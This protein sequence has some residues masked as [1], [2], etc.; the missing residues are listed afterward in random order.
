[1]FAEFKY[2]V[3][4]P[5]LTSVFAFIEIAVPALLIYTVS[6]EDEPIVTLKALAVNVPNAKSPLQQLNKLH[7]Q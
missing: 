6:T 1:M 7:L 5:N 2:L 3:A 4:L